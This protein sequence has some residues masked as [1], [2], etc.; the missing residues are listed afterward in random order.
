MSGKNFIKEIKEKLEK[1]KENIE[2]ELQKFTQKEE[3]HL[4]KRRVRFPHFDGE[5]GSA[6][7]EEGADEVEEYSVLLSVK[8]SLEKKLANI[9]KALEKIKKGKYGFCEKCGKEISKEK[10]K[11][12]P[13]TR[14][15]LGCQT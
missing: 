14:F 13:E 3:N 10:L 9:E 1:E 11:A 2:K 4:E 7:L 5:A 8:E 12:C 15:C 6:R